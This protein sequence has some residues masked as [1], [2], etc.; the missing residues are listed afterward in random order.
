MT[1]EVE[2]GRC[3]EWM[4]TGEHFLDGL[5]ERLMHG[6]L[7]GATEIL[8]SAWQALLQPLVVLSNCWDGTFWADWDQRKLFEE[9]I[10]KAQELL[11]N[12]TPID[13][14]DVLVSLKELML[15]NFYLLRRAL[16]VICA[17]VGQA[18]GMTA[19]TETVH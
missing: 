17:D 14:E 13:L 4:D 7:D 15:A 9:N 10:V 5:E 8:R 1:V 19:V 2:L 11:L 3:V 16:S 12:A 18:V 6:D